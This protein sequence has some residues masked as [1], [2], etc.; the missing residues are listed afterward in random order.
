MKPA[1]PAAP[2][3][4]HLPPRKE[5]AGGVGEREE[6]DGEKPGVGLGDK[7][8]WARAGAYIDIADISLAG[9]RQQKNRR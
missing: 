5:K 6:K 3:M 4:G 1:L 8:L 2:L 9:T 7:P